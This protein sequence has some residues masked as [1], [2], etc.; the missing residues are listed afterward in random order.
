VKLAAVKIP[1]FARDDL[2]TFTV[3]GAVNVSTMLPPAS[4]PDS[5]PSPPPSRHPRCTR[6]ARTVAFVLPPMIRPAI[7]PTRPHYDLLHRLVGRLIL[8]AIDRGRHYRR[9]DWV[10]APV[11]RD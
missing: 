11:E 1:R 5:S 6:R 4:H 7:A 8:D 9:L 3:T 2:C 10:G